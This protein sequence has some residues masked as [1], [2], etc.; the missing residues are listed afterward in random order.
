MKQGSI[1]RSLTVRDLTFFS[2][3]NSKNLPGE[4]FVIYCFADCRQFRV[5]SWT[6]KDRAKIKNT[7]TNSAQ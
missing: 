2:G 3:E 4:F 6:L 5:D 7:N 1:F